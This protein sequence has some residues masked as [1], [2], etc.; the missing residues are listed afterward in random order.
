MSNLKTS[1]KKLIFAGII[2]WT[3]INV[4]Y[5]I[6]LTS[7]LKNFKLTNTEII[8]NT[9][10]NNLLL[11]GSCLLIFNNMRY[12]LPRQEKYWYVLTVSIGLSG[13][14]VLITSGLLWLI[15]EDDTHY[16]Q[17]LSQS[18]GIRFGILFLLIGCMSMMSLL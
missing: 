17:S 13:I 1:N 7:I 3:I 18:T 8:V 11:T 15:F 9:L 16:T 14:C 10:I 5:S 2:S 4:V 12:Y 6:I